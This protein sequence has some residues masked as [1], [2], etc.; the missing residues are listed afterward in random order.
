M[1]GFVGDLSPEQERLLQQ[2]RVP[3]GEEK[4]KDFQTIYLL[5]PNY[6]REREREGGE[7]IGNCIARH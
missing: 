7:V 3:W 1:S 5:T 4:D 6:L 2:V